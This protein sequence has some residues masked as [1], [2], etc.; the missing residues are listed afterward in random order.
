MCPQMGPLLLPHQLPCLSWHIPAEGNMCVSGDAELQLA[1]R[2][3]GG[4]QGSVC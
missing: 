4:G 2:G 3:G 1:G